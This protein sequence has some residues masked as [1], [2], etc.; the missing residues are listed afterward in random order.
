MTWPGRAVFAPI[1]TITNV[2]AHLTAWLVPDANNAVGTALL[3]RKPG[4]AIAKVP[5]TV[6][7]AY[8]ARLRH[9]DDPLTLARFDFRNNGIGFL[10]LCFAGVVVWMHAYGVGG[11]GSDPIIAAD[12]PLVPAS[13]PSQAFSY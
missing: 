9:G 3:A 13:S 11:F 5:S 10:R 2:L 4:E 8:E 7:Y 1:Y 12:Q 6:R